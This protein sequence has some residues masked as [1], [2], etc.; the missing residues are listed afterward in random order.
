VALKIDTKVSFPGNIIN[1]HQK[2]CDANLFV[3]P[4]DYEGL[5]NALLEAMMLGLPCISTDCAGADEHIMDGVNG[6]LIPV[7]D[8]DMLV[9]AMIAVL[10]NKDSA[11]ELG[12]K[13]K[14]TAKSFEKNHVLELWYETIT[15]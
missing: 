14:Q 15:K 3:L 12:N 6:Y 10:S 8:E 11:E 4:S 2:I 13:A 1:V 5:S 7:G 9:Q